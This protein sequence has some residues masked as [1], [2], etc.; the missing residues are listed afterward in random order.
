MG[1]Q[2]RVYGR[3]V[4]GKI[5]RKNRQYSKL[6]SSRCCVHRTCLG[7]DLQRKPRC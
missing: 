3:E 6:A 5:Q 7:I 4:Y 2:S 1:I